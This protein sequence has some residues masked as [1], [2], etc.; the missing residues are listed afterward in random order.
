[1]LRLTR[2]LPVPVGGRGGGGAVPAGGYHNH[3]LPLL[4]VVSMEGKGL[5]VV[6]VAEGPDKG[7]RGSNCGTENKCNRIS[8]RG[9]TKV[10]GNLNTQ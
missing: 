10:S 4:V 8:R 3:L 7:W 5:G 1:M 6:L 9:D 2:G